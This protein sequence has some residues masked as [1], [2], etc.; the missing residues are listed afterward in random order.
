MKPRSHPGTPRDRGTL[1]AVAAPGDLVLVRCPGDLL[2]GFVSTI[3]SSAYSHTEIY[4][5]R[6]WSVSTERQGIGYVPTARNPW[7]DLYRCD[8]GAELLQLAA[9]QVGKPFDV[10]MITLWRLLR[11]AQQRPGFTCS[12]LAAFCLAQL[13]YHPARTYGATSGDVARTP[14]LQLIAS[15][16]HG[17]QVD[18]PT[19]GRQGRSPRQR[20]THPAARILLG[21][22][23][24]TNAAP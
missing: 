2:G 1:A 18:E 23:S 11:D 3:G 5:G 20:P 14:G 22:K 24:T 6:G 15:I 16:R 4:A 9:A 8:H 13:G 19:D 12:G 10:P 17:A 7:I 21:K